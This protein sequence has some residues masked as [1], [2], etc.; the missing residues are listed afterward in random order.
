MTGRMTRLRSFIHQSPEES[1]VEVE[2]S[3]DLHSCCS[4][5]ILPDD[6]ELY[7]W[8]LLVPS[9]SSYLVSGPVGAET[10]MLHSRVRWD[11]LGSEM[12]RRLGSR[13]DIPLHSPH[14]TYLLH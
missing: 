3:C 11:L 14:Y 13:A 5:S 8:Y 7:L 9:T 10:H 2:G 1:T 6:S 12:T 4:F